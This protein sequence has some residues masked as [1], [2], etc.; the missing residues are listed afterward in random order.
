MGVTVM[1]VDTPITVRVWAS[2]GGVPLEGF[3]GGDMPEDPGAA[4]GHAALA[5]PGPGRGG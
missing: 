3:R 4:P 2:S 5:A 1:V